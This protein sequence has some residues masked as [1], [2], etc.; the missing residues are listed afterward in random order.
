MTIARSL[1]HRLAPVLAVG[2]LV[3]GCSS[4]S[5]GADSSP[6]DEATATIEVPAPPSGS[7]GGGPAPAGVPT[8]A[9]C[10]E[11][12]RLTRQELDGLTDDSPD[13]WQSFAF[14]LQTVANAAD[15]AEFRTALTELATGALT[16]SESLAAGEKA[17]NA[18]SGFQDAVPAVDHLC[19]QAGAPLN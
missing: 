19:K 12:N 9:A 16:A 1:A 13:H 8:A 5:S 4:A 10:T 2:L 18:T 17:G 15:D 7:S 11:I 14:A 6:A 3:A